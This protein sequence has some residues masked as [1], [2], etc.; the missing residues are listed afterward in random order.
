M[1]GPAPFEFSV[2]SQNEKFGGKGNGL[3]LGGGGSAAFRMSASWQLVV[4][5]GGCKM[6][7]LEEN[8]SG[9]SLTYMVGPR[10][11]TRD[12]GRWS[13]NLEFLIGGNKLTEEQMFPQIKAAVEAAQGPQLL[14]TAHSLYTEEAATNRVAVSS[15]GGVNYKLNGALM[16]RV[17]ELSYQHFWTGSLNGRSYP[18]SVKVSSGLVLRIGTW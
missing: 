12:F 8:F 7:G 6:I 17:A 4:D 15:G 18:S 16:I 13:A 1:A 11:R 14:P 9:D 2:T 5:V 10:Y 3:C